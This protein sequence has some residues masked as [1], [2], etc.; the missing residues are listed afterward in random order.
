[1]QPYNAR[2]L[3]ANCPG[4]SR[5][6][7]VLHRWHMFIKIDQVWPQAL[8]AKHLAIFGV[9]TAKKQDL[10]MIYLINFR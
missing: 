5:L 2:G 6:T 9:G 4:A 8:L 10:I 1:M 3:K 7:V